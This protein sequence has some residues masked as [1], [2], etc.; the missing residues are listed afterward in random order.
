MNMNL[1][2]LNLGL[3]AL[4]LGFGLV[5][6]QSAFT[7]KTTTPNYAKDSN[8]NWHLITGLTQVNSETEPGENQYRCIESASICKAYFSY[9][10][11]M[12]NA[13]DF[14]LGSEESGVVEIGN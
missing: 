3:V 11:P 6:T 4:V 10:N 7:P 13:T 9:P 5:L 2:K 8:G 14:E 12:P 1:K